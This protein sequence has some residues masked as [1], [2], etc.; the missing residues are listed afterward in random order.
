MRKKESGWAK[1]RRMLN[2]M[3]KALYATIVLASLISPITP[4]TL[5]YLASLAETQAAI[6]AFAE[7][8]PFG[9]HKLIALPD[10][11]T[12]DLNTDARI[13]GMM[14]VKERS[15][16]L[17]S[18][19]AVF[20][21]VP[22]RNRPFTVK[23]G[24][25]QIRVVGTRFDVYSGANSD[26]T[27]ERGTRITVLDGAIQVTRD[28]TSA[29]SILRLAAGDQI[30]IFDDR[31]KVALLRHVTEPAAGRLTAW[32]HGAIEFED[33]TLREILTEYARYRPVQYDSKDPEILNQRFTGV[34]HTNDVA[35]F[36]KSLEA[37]CI[38]SSFEGAGRHIVLNRPSS[39]RRGGQCH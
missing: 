36:L 33:R 38:R 8:A 1:V 5:H 12:V 6:V 27:G 24:H 39:K 37:E 21:V 16:H 31:T 35:P 11:S 30:E 18:G 22:D 15:M 23:V 32:Q 9:D 17:E 7:H 2:S 29:G 10:G 13:S 25:V 28:D 4:Q 3:V 34:F 14:S 19:E 20:Q 26:Y